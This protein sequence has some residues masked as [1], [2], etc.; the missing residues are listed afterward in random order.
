MIGLFD[1]SLWVLEQIKSPEYWTELEKPKVKVDV[2]L[3]IP[4]KMDVIDKAQVSIIGQR[5]RKLVSG[6]I[7]VSTSHITNIYISVL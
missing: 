4:R 7:F 3:F 2:N 6:W 5:L 1:T